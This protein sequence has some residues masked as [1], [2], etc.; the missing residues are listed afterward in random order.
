MRILLAVFALLTLAS[1]AAAQTRTS[2]A[3]R[4]VA[5][6]HDST[7][8]FKGDLFFEEDDDVDSVYTKLRAH[9]GIRQLGASD[10]AVAVRDPA[11]CEEWI[12][13]ITEMLRQRGGPD[14]DTEGY[15][16]RMIRYGPYMMVLGDVN[17]ARVPAGTTIHYILI[18]LFEVTGK[19]YLGVMLG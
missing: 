12:P 1:T 3:C 5:S 7:V 8:E 16:F 11:V 19:R 4:A 15:L 9:F 2:P 13:A 18:F 6:L 14:H 17:P 10:P